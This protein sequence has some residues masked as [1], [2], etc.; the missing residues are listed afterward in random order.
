MDCTVHGIAKSRTQ[1][2][3]SLSFHFTFT[4]FHFHV[5]QRSFIF[6]VTME[7][8]WFKT[9][10]EKSIATPSHTYLWTGQQ[11]EQFEEPEG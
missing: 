1:L 3:D 9:E 2:T 5:L 10:M 7:E 8:K 4:H 11:F 6:N